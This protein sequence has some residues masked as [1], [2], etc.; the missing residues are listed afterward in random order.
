MRWDRH[1]TDEARCFSRRT[2]FYSV[3]TPFR[4]E[5]MVAT[6]Y[7]PRSTRFGWIKKL[8]SDLDMTLSVVIGPMRLHT[9]RDA[10]ATTYDNGAFH[11]IDLSRAN[12]TGD[13]VMHDAHLELSHSTRPELEHIRRTAHNSKQFIRYNTKCESRFKT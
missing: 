4:I 1:K 3:L 8:H 6:H 12:P 7:L 11:L 5:L 9:G 10:V 13:T 2:D